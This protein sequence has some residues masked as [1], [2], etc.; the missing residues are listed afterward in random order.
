MNNKKWSEMDLD[1]LKLE[2]IKQLNAEGS[3]QMV[4]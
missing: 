1:N 3:V 4:R 2:L